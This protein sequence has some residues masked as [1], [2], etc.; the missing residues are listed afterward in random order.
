MFVKF[1]RLTFL[2]FF[3]GLLLALLG[4]LSSAS[5]ATVHSDVPP[6]DPGGGQKFGISKAQ[7]PASGVT[8]LATG[9][10]VRS[11]ASSGNG[12]PAQTGS[13]SPTLFTLSEP[14]YSYDYQGFI[15]DVHFS[16]LAD[17]RGDVAVNFLR[18]NTPVEGAFTCGPVGWGTP[19]APIPMQSSAILQSTPY[20][21]AIVNR[22]YPSPVSTFGY[23]PQGY[24]TVTLDVQTTQL[25]T[26]GFIHIKATWSALRFASGATLAVVDPLT[27]ICAA[28]GYSAALAIPDCKDHMPDLPVGD[29]C[30]GAPA[31]NLLDP[32]TLAVAAG[33]WVNCLFNPR[34]G[35]DQHGH[36]S[37]A[38]SASA[39]GQ[40]S[41]QLQRMGDSFQYA[42]VCGELG[43]QVTSGPLASFHLNTCA[44]TSFGGPMRLVLGWGIVIFFGWWAINFV[45]NVLLGTFNIRT[46]N[47]VGKDDK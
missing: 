45:I 10:D 43:G 17:A 42:T 16:S 1:L 34:A 25:A 14:Y 47:P 31:I 27:A 23:C 7:F 22:L 6:P 28:A 18:I 40:G 20:A 41:Y 8:Q 2:F 4:P 24:D 21:T 39:L 33:F 19:D 9:W 38:M 29:Y 3:A 15:V 46:P 44:W 32:P 36:I 5:A 11:F 12:D 13:T 35:F 26:F 30:A 37:T